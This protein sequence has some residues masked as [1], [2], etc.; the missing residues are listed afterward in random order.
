MSRSWVISG[1]PIN[2]AYSDTDEPWLSK[3]PIATLQGD[4][5][6]LAYIVA[7]LFAIVRMSS[8]IRTYGLK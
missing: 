8:V 4:L 5:P 1:K 7:G 6:N 2:P 3:A